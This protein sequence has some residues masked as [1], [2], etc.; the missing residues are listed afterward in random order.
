MDA[1]VPLIQTLA[2]VL[3]IIGVL[4]KF[5]SQVVAILNAIRD[6][7]SKGSSVK[8]GPFELG[9]D[10]R[11]QNLDEQKE[12]IVQ[13]AR[14]VFQQES[15]TQTD[16]VPIDAPNLMN[17]VVLAEELVM[18]DLQS[19]YGVNINRQVSLGNLIQ[20]D[21]MFVKEGAAYGIEIKYT[22]ARVSMDSLRAIVSR[23]HSFS[24]SLRWRRFSLIFVVVCEGEIPNIEK[25]REHL[26]KAVSK[27]GDFVTIRL[28][29]LQE[30]ATR[31]GLELSTPP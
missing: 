20:L 6:R 30:L 9:E 31:F 11:V 21:G 19:E 29:S 12:R 7:I 18:R 27:Y 25:E 24:H 2:W 26:Q 22:R 3:L 15:S 13:E 4:W 5:Y 8:A 23:L 28:Y 1:W 14:E 16:F 10:L 17:R